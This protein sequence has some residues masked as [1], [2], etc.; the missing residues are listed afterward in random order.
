MKSVFFEK[1]LQMRNDWDSMW[2][3]RMMLPPRMISSKS[4]KDWLQVINGTTCHLK[5]N[6]KG[7]KRNC[8]I[9]VEININ[10]KKKKKRF[11]EKK[12]SRLE[13]K[14]RRG[15]KERKQTWK[16]RNGHSLH[17]FQYPHG[18]IDSNDCSRAKYHLQVQVGLQSWY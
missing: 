6:S 10:L 17:G 15:D 14:K 16:N 5:W 18:D 9:V 8:R 1:S 3:I 4:D 7:S 2:N 13:K 12:I 11:K